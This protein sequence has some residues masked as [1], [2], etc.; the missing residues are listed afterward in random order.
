MGEAAKALKDAHKNMDVDQVRYCYYRLKI[1]GD[2]V[3]IFYEQNR[4][5]ST[6]SQY[7]SRFTI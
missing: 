6:E 1:M 4:V 5:F 7:F 3:N 2:I